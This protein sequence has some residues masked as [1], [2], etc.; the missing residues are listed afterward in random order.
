ML[1]LL[2]TPE[3]EEGGASVAIVTLLMA[4][5]ANTMKQLKS[6]NMY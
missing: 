2:G 6:Q 5:Y 3:D 4:G 1:H